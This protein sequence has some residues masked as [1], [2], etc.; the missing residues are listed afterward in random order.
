MELS[1]LL[2]HQF[3]E[4]L[5]ALPTENVAEIGISV[6]EKMAKQIISIVGEEGFTSLYAR[7]QYLVHS[8]FP[9]LPINLSVSQAEHRFEELKICLAG[10]SPALARQ[11]N[12]LLLTTFTDILATL[13]GEE[14]TTSILQL[15]WGN[16]LPNNMASEEFHNE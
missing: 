14:L 8:T 1:D 9:W 2:R 16:N 6:W 7:S 11:A 13:I 3:I 10:Q 4:A 12:V 5:M 15:A